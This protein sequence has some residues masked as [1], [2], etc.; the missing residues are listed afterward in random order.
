MN[1]TTNQTGKALI[2]ELM[3]GEWPYALKFGGDYESFEMRIVI[4]RDP[5]GRVIKTGLNEAGDLGWLHCSLISVFSGR[6][7]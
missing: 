7:V 4:T 3:A 2:H 1:F 5:D 6:A